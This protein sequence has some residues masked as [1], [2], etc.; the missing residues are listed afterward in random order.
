M[1][2]E[3]L[4]ADELMGLFSDLATE[5]R[6][7]HIIGNVHLAGGAAMVL[8]Y[9]SDLTTGDA[10][11]LFEP[12]GPMIEAIH[13]VAAKRN[14]PRSW[15]NNQASVYFSRVAVPTMIIFD[16]PN[17]RVMVTPAEHLLAMKILAAR[18]VRDRDDALKL[19]NHLGWTERESAVE[20]F[21]RY[22]PDEELDANPRRKA[23]VDSL[24]GV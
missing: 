2:E 15:M 8:A 22:F 24:T 7:R 23:F 11:A 19:M 13:S 16:D 18:T 20:A 3:R 5:L 17:L 12:D 9:G 4:T 10:D 1:S 14:L 6:A 21:E